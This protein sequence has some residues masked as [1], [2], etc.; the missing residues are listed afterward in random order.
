VLAAALGFLE[1]HEPDLI[2][3]ADALAVPP[4]E[5]VEARRLLER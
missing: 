4:A 2:A 3:A 5:L 1:A